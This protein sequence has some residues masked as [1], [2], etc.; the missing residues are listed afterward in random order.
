MA[1]RTTSARKTLNAANLA[2][3]GPER[4]AAMLVEVA[5]GD[6]IWKRRLKMELASELGAADLAFEI[7]RRLTTL[8]TSRTRVSW[9]KRPE[10]IRDLEALRLM[11]AGR[12]IPLDARLGLDRMIAWFD[13]YPG[14]TVR[15]KDPKDELG[16]AFDAA[17]A[18]LAASA[19][20]ARAEVA[21]PVL[22]D[23]VLTRLSDWGRWMGR[24]TA[25]LDRP[26][27]RRLLSELTAGRPAPTGRLAL[28]VRKLADRVDDFE[29]W[30]GT[31]PEADRAR[32]EIGAEIARRLATA[33]R[34]A[35]AR[36]ALEAS[37]APAA[38]SRWGRPAGL[39][40]PPP[41]VW[42]TAEIAVLDSE[43][44]SEEAA[45]ARWALFERSL[46]ANQL[47]ALIAALPDFEDVAALDRAHGIAAGWPDAD[48]GLAFLM[49]WPAHREAAEMILTRS[50]SLRGTAEEFP[51]W[52]GRLAGRYPVAAMLLLRVRIRTLVQLGAVTE[53]A[54]LISEAAVL[55]DQADLPPGVPD[56]AVFAAE[57]ETDIR[58][59]RWRR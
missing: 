8:A 23:A 45:A 48:K 28:V 41:D 43:G 17:T 38:P 59:S 31:I 4:L 6:R 27:A 19:A 46:D 44:R 9:R 16:Q 52:A 26:V 57:L 12:L 22:A 11:I 10:L 42:L 53:A 7:D 36:A 18:D 14:L 30:A 24:A 47:R 13:L 25:G 15:V 54:A 29:L 20:A 49:N 5:G 55:A 2:A 3:L 33:G 40:S 50:G 56:H 37:R 51:L 58:R 21:G 1:K 34:A 39:P 32:P 35:E